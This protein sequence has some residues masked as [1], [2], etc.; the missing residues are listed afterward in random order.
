M[1]TLKQIRADL[2]KQGENRRSV[3]ND[4]AKRNN[5]LGGKVS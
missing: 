3:S 1:I 2:Y 5:E 4:G